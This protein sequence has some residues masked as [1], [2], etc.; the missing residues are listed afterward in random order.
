MHIRREKASLSFVVRRS[1]KTPLL[2]QLPMVAGS[3]P[4]ALSPSH[5]GV[6]PRNFASLLCS[7]TN[8][9]NFQSTIFEFPV[10]HYVCPQ[11]FQCT[12]EHEVLP[13]K[14]VRSHQLGMN[15]FR[16]SRITKFPFSSDTVAYASKNF[17]EKHRIQFSNSIRLYNF[18]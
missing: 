18:M 2:D 15:R 8:I 10:I 3:R 17:H 4:L 7:K 6:F 11:S 1:L 5:R 12:W 16:V 9:S 13:G 14:K